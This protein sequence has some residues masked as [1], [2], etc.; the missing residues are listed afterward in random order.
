MTRPTRVLL[1]GDLHLG[2]R[3]RR[4]P[5]RAADADRLGPR[6]A[7]ERIVTTARALD[8]DAVAF[9]GDL[10]HHL[11]DRFEALGP[12]KGA[13]QRLAERG[14]VAL[15]VAGNHDA[16]ALNRV[17]G[18]LGGEALHVLGADGGWEARSLEPEGATALEFVGRSFV[19]EHETADPMAAF[20]EALRGP[21]SPEGR[22]RI[23]LL[24]TQLDAADAPYAPT[25]RAALEATGMPWFLGHVHDPSPLSGSRPVGYL[26]SA[27][28]LAADECGARGPWLATVGPEGLRDLVQLPLAPLRRERLELDVGVL[29]EAADP[30]AELEALV[31]EGATR[32]LEAIGAEGRATMQR[33]LD[34]APEAGSLEEA[35]LGPR[36]VGLRL[37]L[38]GRTR[39]A[40]RLRDALEAQGSL[41]E[42][43][44][45]GGGIQAW[46]QKVEVAFA[47]SHDLEEL[48]RGNDPIALLARKL[49]AIESGDAE[50]GEL[51]AGVLA[52]RRGGFARAWLDALPRGEGDEP[53]DVEEELRSALLEAGQEA[54]DALLAQREEAAA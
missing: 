50:A 51:V 10:I 43:A 26:G 30:V 8:V 45:H 47:R 3:P 18:L 42:Y 41:R 39:H 17:A 35:T 32:I 16:V 14:V 4:L 23:G 27:T 11:E 46:I 21:T 53:V 20:P 29:E 22:V 49:L 54:L 5:E 9:A 52:T 34:V 7:L 28:A 12:L 1:V 40:V 15:A 36:A 38:V 31:E 25:T 33:L 19:R 6:E 13:C 2:L 44:T 48:A 37:R 24:H